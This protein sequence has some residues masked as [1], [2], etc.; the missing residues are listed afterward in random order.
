MLI[1]ANTKI[2]EAGIKSER[3]MIFKPGEVQWEPSLTK[4]VMMK[5]VKDEVENPVEEPGITMP[6]M[7]PAVGLTYQYLNWQGYI[8]FARYLKHLYESGKWQEM[9]D[10]YFKAEK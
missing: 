6:L 2:V 4:S 5:R 1:N 3:W 8:A 10:I 9:Q 7:T